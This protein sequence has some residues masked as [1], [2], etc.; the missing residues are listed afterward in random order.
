MNRKGTQIDFD[1]VDTVQFLPGTSTPNPTYN[2]HTE[3]TA[4]AP[5][6]SKI[7][8]FEAELTAKP[9]RELTIGA[10]YAYTH[11]TIP[12]TD[13]PNTPLVN[14]PTQVF[15][16]FTPKHALSGFLDY[17]TE[18]ADDGMGLRFHVDANYAGPQYSF[19]AE[20]VLTES[21]FIVN[22]RIALTDIPL[23]EM[24][25]NLTVALW[26]RNLLDE[27]HIYRRSNANNNTI[28]AYGNFNPP[29]TFGV[30]ASIEF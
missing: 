11:S 10:S 13:N 1:N 16:V 23:T 12:A 15:V 20:N 19:Q 14:D 7:R 29:R 18:L 21:S 2:L 27:D 3:N 8:G 6:T 9:I 25:T 26:S 17:D 4:N 28:G 30:E 24:G 5:G 22:G